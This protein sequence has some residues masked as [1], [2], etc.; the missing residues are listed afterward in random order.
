M[1]QKINKAAQA[2]G[3]LGKGK[4]KTMTPAAIEARRH[5]AKKSLESR[6]RTKAEKE[7]SNG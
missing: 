4:T 5:A 2:L 6:A 1:T 3:R 7:A